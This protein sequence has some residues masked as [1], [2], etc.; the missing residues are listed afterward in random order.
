MEEVLVG[1]EPWHLLRWGHGEAELS[2]RAPSNRVVVVGDGN[3]VDMAH[4]SET[5]AVAQPGVL[6]QQRW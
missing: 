3:C 2:Q 5:F 4:I 6:W 1:D